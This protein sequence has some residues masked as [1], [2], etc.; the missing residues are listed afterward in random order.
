M[1]IFILVTS[2]GAYIETT[3]TP[4]EYHQMVLFT[5]ICLTDVQDTKYVESEKEY[6]SLKGF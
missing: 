4:V 2:S 3:A 5:R 6:V 1:Q